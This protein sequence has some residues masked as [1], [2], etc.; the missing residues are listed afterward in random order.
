VAANSSGTPIEIAQWL[1]ELGLEQYTDAFRENAV[2]AKILQTLTA[3]DL[4]DI[5]V[6]LIGHRRRLLNAIAALDAETPRAKVVTAA[7]E[8]QTPERRQLTVMFCDLVGSTAL[9]TQLDPEDL[10]VLLGAYHLAVKQAVTAFDGFVAKYM[11][12]GVLVYFGYPRA[13]E[14]DA[15]RAIR[16]GL[17]A[18]GAVSQ[19]DGRG[20]KLQARVGIAT[21]FVVVGDLIG[22]GSAQEQAVVGETPNLA[23]R[24]QALA[25][26]G[27]LVIAASTRQ[28][29]G[30]LFDLEDLGPQQLAG[31]ADPQP[32]WLVLRESTEVSRFEALHSQTS[33]LVGRDEEVEVL[34]RRWENAKRGEGRVV[35]ISGEPGIGKSRLTAAL[36]ERIGTEPH[37]RWRFFCSPH[38][39]DSALYPFIAHLEH[40]AGFVRDDDSEERFRKLRE[41]AVA[42]QDEDDIELV[43][44]LLSLP[45]KSAALNLSPQL[46]REKLF[47]SLLKQ[48]EF[49]ARRRPVL[50]I[51]EDAHWIDP[52]SREM[53]DLAV[54]RV[55]RL[56]VLLMITFRSE[57]Q[58]PWGGRSHV[59]SLVLNRLDEANGEALVQNLAG[60]V[61]LVSEI[62]MKIVERA[63]GV[64]LFL[65]ELT[66]TVLESA[67]EGPATATPLGKS[68][69]GFS[70]PATLHAS[71][72]ARLDRLAPASQEVAQIGAVL[73]REFAYSL[74]EPV[75]QREEATLQAALAQLGDAG[76]LFCR[77]AAPHASY[78]FKHALVQDAAYSTLLR[79]K[80][81]EL[82]ARV[83][84]VLE[85]GFA[86][87]V[88]RQPELLAHHLSAAGD[89]ARAIDQWLKA[90]QYAAA[91]SAH[92]EAIRHFGRGLSTLATLPETS[93]RDGREIEL[94]LALGSSLFTAEGFASV[95][96]GAAYA[97]A[98]DLAEQ[99][100][101]SHQQFMTVYGLWQLANGAGRV[102]DCR[103]LSTQLQQLTANNADDELRLQAHHSAW[104]T[105]L[106]AGDPAAALEHSEA[107]RC[108]YDLNRHRHHRQLYGGHDPGACA[109]YL[110]AQ[111]QWALG[112]P[113]R[114][115]ALGKEGLAI[116]EK[117]VHPFSLGLALQYNAM[118][119]LDRREPEF[120]LQ[121][122]E[123][124]EALVVE[125]RI[126]LVLDLALLRG[127]AMVLQGA[128]EQAI[129]HLREGLSERTTAP[130]LRC[131][132]LAKL[133]DAL[134]RQGDNA[135]ALA[136]AKDGLNVA[137]ET[138]HRQWLAELH[139][140]EGDALCGLN[141][142]DDSQRAFEEALRVARR[143]GAKAYE[144][145]AATS[146]ARLLGE[147]RRRAEAHDVLAPVYRSF[148]E[149]FETADLMEAKL[150][151]DQLT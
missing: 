112:Y 34:M 39:Q 94:Q 65:E 67:K 79:A 31:F 151:L 38:H 43:A 148:T 42:T 132:G 96:A 145:R 150:L 76:L 60:H 47:A 72:V 122:L 36:S 83:A 8:T 35:L 52:T 74:I 11:G 126:G 130:R 103:R 32:A 59:T 16:A 84:A 108:L 26:P 71:L 117:I 53:L 99:Q 137:E 86:D 55:R 135:A 58:A 81:Q 28:Q 33:A 98:R 70:V 40:A 147:Q 23:A 27:H 37:E 75:A 149:G 46:K 56:P 129:V 61:G 128:V 123:A 111:A 114:A 102:H 106:F 143:Q 125:H 77:G 142:L 109:H 62:V 54:D 104:A 139:R 1:R 22:E 3:E 50:M 30:E 19:L 90:G 134:A 144:L 110:G 69:D 127:S 85:Q 13:H 89:A 2:D 51:F 97:R 92:L 120:A 78:L 118:L 14:D 146:L 9:S 25:A 140:V 141:V 57:F 48:L 82:H 44:E 24:L 7:H 131:Y 100:G 64:P 63:D 15:E 18:I 21:G 45:T 105:C 6:L 101:N 29:V 10:R 107:G 41:L 12:D 93:T 116:S 17:R 133:A 95:R 91:R 4:R 121:R 20:A 5:G 66:K 87:Q 68:P 88:E 73:G 49:E 119:H 113:E 124:V 136:V 138:G 115:L 80:R